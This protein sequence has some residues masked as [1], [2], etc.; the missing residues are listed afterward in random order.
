MVAVGSRTLAKSEAF[1]SSV[2]GCEGAHAYGS[3]EEVLADPRVDAVYI[4]LPSSLHLQWVTKAA[5]KGLH[6]LCEKPIATVNYLYPMQ[7]CCLLE[8]Y[9]VQSLS[10]MFYLQIFVWYLLPNV[11]HQRIEY[12]QQY[13]ICP[14]SIFLG[15]LWQCYS[16]KPG[17]VK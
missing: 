15:L 8:V 9:T 5:E 17:I 13:F 11:F 3:Y 6:I 7:E 14:L 4:P 2:E 12:V 10:M 16:G 1:I